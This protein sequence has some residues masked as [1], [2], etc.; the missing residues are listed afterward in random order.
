[1]ALPFFMDSPLSPASRSLLAQLDSK[2]QPAQG[3]SI[4]E[5]KSSGREAMVRELFELGLVRIIDRGHVIA[6]TSLDRIARTV[7]ERC[8]G[9]AGALPD[10]G[11]L[12]EEWGISRGRCKAILAAL[13]FDGRLLRQ[14]GRLRCAE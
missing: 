12:A 11:E 5:L 1:M 10:T 2:E 13:V 4:V 7:R 3:P 8:A 14:D 9:N 6:E